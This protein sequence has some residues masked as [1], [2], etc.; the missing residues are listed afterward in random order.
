MAAGNLLLPAAILF[1]GLTFAKFAYAAN[2]L[3][4]NVISESEFYKVQTQ[5]LFPV[6]KSAWE[7]NRDKVEL[8]FEGEELVLCGDGR[9]DSPGHS[10]KYC[11]YSLME[12]CSGLIVNFELVQVGESVLSDDCSHFDPVQRLK[13]SQNLEKEGLIRCLHHVQTGLLGPVKILA[14]DRHP[15]ITSYM[16]TKQKHINHQ[17]DIWHLA[18]SIVKKISS[19]TKSADCAPIQPWIQAINNK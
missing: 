2:I 15:Q 12:Q 9:C 18:K 19:V 16:R 13:Y 8:S 10:A 1:S 14:T 6:I 11:T 4:L 7:L 5:Y 17:F 3:K